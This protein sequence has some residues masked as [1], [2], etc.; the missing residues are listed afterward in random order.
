MLA[1]A[2]RP[3]HFNQI[4]AMNQG[5]LAA[6]YVGSNKCKSCHMDAFKTWAKTPRRRTQ[7]NG[8]AGRPVKHPVAIGISIPVECVKCCTR[9][10]SSIPA[11]TTIWLAIR[12]TGCLAQETPRQANAA[13]ADVQKHNNDDLRNVGCESCHGPASEHVKNP[14]NM[15]VRQLINPYRP[16]E[17]ERQLE[18]ALVKDSNDAKALQ[19]WLQLSAKPPGAPSRRSSCIEV[20]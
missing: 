1:K 9:P 6:T 15:Q 2:A 7:G 19:Q 20:P 17:K 18:D 5:G 8:D 10:A 4:P 14:N 12:K 3:L 13:G 16:T 11:A